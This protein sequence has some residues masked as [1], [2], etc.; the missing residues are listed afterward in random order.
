[1]EVFENTR[2]AGMELKNRIIRAATHEG[3]GGSQGFPREELAKIYE[4]LARGG[5]GAIITGYAGVQREGRAW[6]N[7]PLIDRDEAIPAYQRIT[8]AIKP[9]GTPLILQLAHGGGM[10]KPEVTGGPPL[11]PSRHRY[12]LTGE[13]AVELTEVQIAEI[14]ESFARGVERA[15]LAGYDGV[16]IHAAHGY[17]LSEF[18]SPWLNRR[19]DRWGGSTENRARV[20]REI[21]ERSRELVGDYPMLVKINGDETQPGGMRVEE[22]VRVAQLLQQASFDA[23]E[24]SCGSDDFF[25]TVRVPRVPVDAILEMD[26]RL[27]RASSLKKRITRFFLPRVIKTYPGLENYNTPAAE[28][29]KAA[30]DIPVIV[31]GGIRKL[32]A[33]REI[34]E[35]GRADYVSMCRPF[36]IEPNI[37]EKM[38]AGRQ[39]E[40]RCINCGY[41]LI[42]V[43]AAPLR[44]YFGRL[45]KS[46]PESPAGPVEP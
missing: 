4:R 28:R 12:Q 46:V 27:R 20:L 19:T 37:V 22:A 6:P 18:L 34:I 35:R 33:I 40:S 11:A 15:K 17:L 9:Y 8:A 30:V 14:V 38:R 10:V 3:M 16:E 5:V 41:C 29:I 26:P 25:Y 13:T 36:I 32:S 42:G 44:C 43:P 31:L 45:P 21:A 23:V 2:L 24:V 39:E 7:M 1:M